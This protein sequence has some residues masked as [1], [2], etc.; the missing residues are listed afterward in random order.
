MK[1]QTQSVIG[2]KS[3]KHVGVNKQV[4]GMNSFKVLLKKKTRSQKFEY[5]NIF[6]KNHL[7]DDTNKHNP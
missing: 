2:E 4:T 5:I 1:M 7:Q 6:K 3:I